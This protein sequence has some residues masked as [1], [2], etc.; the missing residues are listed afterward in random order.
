LDHRDQLTV[1]FGSRPAPDNHD[2][3]KFIGGFAMLKA[4]SVGI[5]VSPLVL[6]AI[7]AAAGA[8]P[9]GAAG[10]AAGR[11]A[12]GSPASVVVRPA[13]DFMGSLSTTA[14]PTTAECVAQYQLECLSPQQIQQA[15]NLQPLYDRGLTGRGETIAIVDPFGSPTI[16]SDLATFDQAYGLPAPPS[17]SIIQPAGAVPPYNPSTPDA[18]GWARETTI[19]V[20]CAHM[21]APGASILLVE[22]PVDE[23][24][25]TAGFPQIEQAEKYVIEHHLA[26]VISQSFGAGEP[27]FPS[28]QS[29]LALR[30]AYTEAQANGV[31]VL[32]ATG[33]WGA[34]TQAS[35]T[36]LSTTPAVQWP[37]SDPLVTAVGGVDLNYNTQGTAFGPPSV[38]ND[39]Y[40]TVANEHFIGDAGPN[41]LASGGGLSSVFSRP[42][43]QNGVAD[44][45]GNS[46]GIPDISMNAAWSE[47]VN[48]YES[49]AGLPAGWS[50]GVGTS[51]ASPE[52][53][54]IVALADQVAGH[55]LGFIN[56]ALYQLYAE[57]APGIVPVSSGNNTVSFTQ[58]GTQYTVDGYSATGGYNLATGVGTLNAAL[59]VP[60][61]AAAA[62]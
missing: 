35:S 56:P 29:L 39:T 54:G 10:A 44:V 55:P 12:G 3:C 11:Q 36:S 43:Y 49:F 34:A 59:F 7:V 37:A 15:F 38:W 14:P 50:A 42:S 47:W 20:E 23:T 62:G 9:A 27:S 52:F 60:E 30:G 28:A 41:P 6:A 32:A 21:I 24:T 51:V 5:V 17:F 22:T 8:G 2:Q 57:H 1:Q 31:T 16:S 19:D 18:I 13:N 53:A 26:N 4:R 45:V 48:V 40:N 61:L 33:D 25:G 58:N 46:R